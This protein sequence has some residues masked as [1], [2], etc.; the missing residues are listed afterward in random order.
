MSI[1]LLAGA[2]SRTTEGAV[3]MANFIVLPM[4]FLSGSFFPLDGA[5]GWLQGISL[6]LPLR[7][8]NDGMLD[9]MVRGQG[10]VGAL[11]PM[12]ILL[13]FTVVLTA[14]AAPAVPLGDDM[15]DHDLADL[16]A[17]DLARRMAA[18]QSSAGEAVEASLARIASRDPGVN[19][20]SVVLADQARADA[21]AARRADGCGGAPGPLHGVPVAIKEEIDVAGCVTTFGGRGNSTPAA[22]DSAGRARLRQ[23]GAVVVGKTRMPEF[24]Q[25]PFTESVDGG[26]TRN[27]WDRPAP[28]GLQRGHRRGGRAGMVPVALGGDGGVRSGSR[29]PAAGSSASSRPGAG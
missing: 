21:G 12:G 16:S 11:A 23:A 25:W 9:V 7:H 26:T 4:A 10:P 13:A 14:I 15:N 27:P 24:G 2:V 20:F 8:L 18:G 17:A 5:P 6:A 28:P 19:A 22:A 3:N 29:P 1:G